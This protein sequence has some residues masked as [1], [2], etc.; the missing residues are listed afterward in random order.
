VAYMDGMD[1]MML[2]S[3]DISTSIDK[4][5]GRKVYFHNTMQY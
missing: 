2:T 5:I 3:Y 1:G 4:T